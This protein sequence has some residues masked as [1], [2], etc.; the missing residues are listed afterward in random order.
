MEPSSFAD[1]TRAL[2]GYFHGGFVFVSFR[3]CGDVFFD[4]LISKEQLLSEKFQTE[5]LRQRQNFKTFGCRSSRIRRICPF[6]IVVFV[7]NGK[8][9]NKEL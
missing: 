1:V 8:Q 3:S 9:M 5:Y 4:I 2:R 7:K 6:Q